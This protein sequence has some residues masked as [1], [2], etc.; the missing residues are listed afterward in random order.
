M[1]IAFA[2]LGREHLGLEY[3]S[4]VLK[5]EG[6]EV[7]LAYDAGLFGPEDNVFYSPSLEQMFAR[8]EQVLKT[9][10][11]ANPDLVGFTV[12]T[13]TYQWACGVAKEVKQ[14]MGVP[15][16]FGGIHATLV[17]EEVARNDFIDFVVAGEGEY[18]LLDLVDALEAGTINGHIPNLYWE[19]DGVIRSNELRPPVA[20][21]D[22]LPLPDKTL[23]ERDVNY[24]DDYLTMANRGCVFNC[25]F[26]CE[27]YINKL[28]GRSYYRRRSVAGMMDEMLTM[29]ERYGFREVNFFD[30]IFFSDKQ[31]LREFLERYKNEVGTPFRC[32]GHVNFMD[33]EVAELLRDS[34]CYAIEFGFQTANESARRESLHR[35]ESDEANLQAFELCDAFGLRYDLDHIFNLPEESEDDLVKAARYYKDRKMLNRVKCHNLTYF[36][37]LGVVDAGLKHGKLR[38]EDL[39]DL[40]EGKIG[41]FFHVDGITDP[42]KKKLKRSFEKL[43]KLLPLMPNWM[44]N[45]LLERRRYLKMR[46]VPGPAV[47]FGQLLIGLL[48]RDLRFSIYLRYVT[49]RLWRHFFHKR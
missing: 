1:R 38:E 13:G 48:Q 17:P 15:I 11:G 33:H 45:Y 34:G 8:R 40:V 39:A 32:F 28:Y 18:A 43:Y 31:W 21:L 3:L 44:L 23:F 20:D 30:P 14:R 36:P 10:E 16:V 9:I 5:R 37:K 6:H 22:S 46:F 7:V 26:C 2:H 29:K 12:Y 27:S 24:R 41:D 35:F 42:E 19:E 4:A 49:L 47:M 25:S